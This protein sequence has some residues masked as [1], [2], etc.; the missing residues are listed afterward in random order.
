MSHHPQSA[1][2]GRLSTCG[3]LGVPSGPGSGFPSP[4]FWNPEYAPLRIVSPIFVAL[5]GVLTA[6]RAA[7]PPPVRDVALI[8]GRGQLLRFDQDVARVVIAEPKIADAIVVSPRDVM[9]NA[10]GAG[11]TTL[12]I[13][14]GPDSPVRYDVTVSGDTTELDTL[15]ANLAAELKT[16]LAGSDIDFRGTAETIVLTGKAAAT[17]SKRAEALASAYSRKVVNLIEVPDPRQILLQVKFA[18]VDRTALSQFAFNLLSRNP[19]TLGSTSTQQFSQPLFTQLQFQNQ[20]LTSTNLNVSNLLNLFLFRPDL[21]IGATVEALEAQNLLQIL[22][23]PNLIVTEGVEASFL[24]G[25]EFP[26]PTITSTPTS[27]GIAP[28]VT[29]QFKKFGVQLNFTPTPTASGAIHLKVK[30]EVSAL[31]FTNAVVLQGFQIPAISTRVAETDVVLK[32][33]ESFAIAG[34]IDNR[35]SNIVNKVKG[36][37]DIPILGKLFRSNATKKT[38]DEL[39]VVITPRLVKPLAPGESATLP[40]TVEPFLPTV[41]EQKTQQKKTGKGKGKKNDGK[42]AEFAGPRGHDVPK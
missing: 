7:D 25:G 5:L 26:F 8:V 29:V 39:L 38:S 35:V 3:R 17:D 11:H 13:W 2:W 19:K 28:V 12:V 1:V 4:G 22:A 23:E 36:L 41:G 6:A 21:N 31:D 27:A 37:G 14:E 20:Q 15:H 10:K 24:A 30:P 18:S 34:L 32:D 9:V 40:E 33:G 42:Q 16:A